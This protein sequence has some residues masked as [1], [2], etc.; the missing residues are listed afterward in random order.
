MYNYSYLI[1]SLYPYMV[2]LWR[3]WPPT[4]CVRILITYW[5]CIKTYYMWRYF[6]NWSLISYIRIFEFSLTFIN[7]YIFLPNHLDFFKLHEIYGI[8]KMSKIC[9]SN[10]LYFGTKDAIYARP[11]GNMVQSSPR[12]RIQQLKV[13]K[14]CIFTNVKC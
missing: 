5:N 3:H 13:V 6:I 1:V 10:M 14:N 4:I 9:I 11:T 8:S 2:I 7:S 12:S